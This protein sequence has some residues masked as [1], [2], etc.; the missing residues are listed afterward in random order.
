VGR[1]GT[2]L[3][4][5]APSPICLT[6]MLALKQ[7]LEKVIRGELQDLKDDA[8]F[9]REPQPVHRR[10]RNHISPT[11]ET[12]RTAR[13]DRR[14]ARKGGLRRRGP[15]EYGRAGSRAAP[16]P[17]RKRDANRKRGGA[18]G[19]KP[20]WGEEGW[21]RSDRVPQAVLPPRPP[22]LEL[23]CSARFARPPGRRRNGR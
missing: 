15:L 23:P 22:G 1:T 21:R 10:S 13:C 6:D 12:G 2:N 17:A 7:H 5:T 14:P 20:G 16:P 18:P 8:E 3:S 9:G 19:G 11:Q 4:S